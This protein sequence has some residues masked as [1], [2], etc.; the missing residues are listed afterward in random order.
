MKKSR[1]PGV[2]THSSVNIW[3]I[4]HLCKILTTAML[5]W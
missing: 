1:L 4:S 5:H 2:K 3:L